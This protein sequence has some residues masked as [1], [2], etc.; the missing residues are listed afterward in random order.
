LS[1]SIQK[2]LEEVR[3]QINQVKLLKALKQ[4]ENIIKTKD[5]KK[6]EK[7][8]TLVLKGEILFQLGEFEEALEVA[9]GVTNSL[10][11][12]E[13]LIINLDA[14]ILKLYV[15]LF[16]FRYDD[17]PALI[18]EGERL[19]KRINN[20]SD[21][22]VAKYKSIFALAKCSQMTIKE[23]D[24][25]KALEFAQEALKQAE[26]SEDK[27]TIILAQ[28]ITWLPYLLAGKTPSPHPKK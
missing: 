22:K 19:L 7:L 6:E 15:K 26:I 9:D 13:P 2:Q 8:T 16:L 18:K 11:G 20:L 25:E 3:H 10:S 28:L 5:L 1:S 12:K 27:S 14:I 21:K 24:Y 23:R 4:V 17:L